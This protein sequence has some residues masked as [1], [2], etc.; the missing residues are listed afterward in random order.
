MV[1]KIQIIILILTLL[2]APYME[3]KVSDSSNAKLQNLLYIHNSILNEDVAKNGK[4]LIDQTFLFIKDPKNKKILETPTGKQL[5]RQ[6]VLLGNYMAVKSHF[7]K[8]VKE[9][10]AFRQLNMRVLDASLQSMKRNNIEVAPCRFNPKLPLDFSTFNNQIMKALKK[11]IAPEVKSSLSDTILINNARALLNLKYKFDPRFSAN[12]KDI[13]NIIEQFPARNRNQLKK[14]LDEYAVRIKTTEKKLSASEIQNSLNRSVSNLKLN[15]TPEQLL[16]EIQ[17]PAGTLLLTPTMKG[18]E[19][20]IG[21]KDVEKIIKESENQILAEKRETM[22]GNSTTELVKM[23]PFAA[24]E[25]LLTHPEYAGVVCDAINSINQK[26]TDKEKRNRYFKIG[27]AILGGALILTSVGAIA[28]AY[29]LTGSLTGGLVAGTVASGVLST[30]AT[31][32]VVAGLGGA[33]YQGASAYKA[34][35]EM[36]QLENAFITNNGDAKNL[37]DARN[38]LKSFKENRTGAMISLASAGLNAINFEKLFSMA[39]LASKAFKLP[40]LKGTSS[41]FAALADSKIAMKL[42]S[43]MSAAGEYGS[44]KFDTFLYQLAKAGE[45]TRLKILSLLK[46][47]RFTPKDLKEMVEDAIKAAKNCT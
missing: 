18:R 29:I 31:I 3:A 11:T 8:C 26:D 4:K 24:G 1:I 33:L 45:A 5:V 19:K 36:L 6:Q 27:T 9:K 30:S 13:A 10:N 7:E 40:E 37:S 47:N 42:K 41:I 46:N 23:N 34:H 20:H 39:R 17:S 32:G 15:K 43:A 12:P 2:H 14:A 16:L 38:A 35:Q 44:I 21:I 25:M 28:G 22:S